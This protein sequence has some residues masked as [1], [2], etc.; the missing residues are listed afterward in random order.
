LPVWICATTLRCENHHEHEADI[1]WFRPLVEEPSE[2][3]RWR[4]DIAG[5]T[6]RDPD[7]ASQVEAVSAAP[8]S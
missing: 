2:P 1:T 4:P 6:C 7:C 3:A 8:P 5:M